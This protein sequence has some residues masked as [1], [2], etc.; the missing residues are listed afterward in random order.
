MEDFRF[1]LISLSAFKSEGNKELYKLFAHAK[2]KLEGAETINK[3]FYILSDDECTSFSFL[4]CEVFLSIQRKYHIPNDCE[5]LNYHKHLQ[6]YVIQH[7][8]SELNKTIPKLQKHTDG[9]EKIV[10]K[11]NISIDEKLVKLLDLEDRIA[12]C[13]FGCLAKCFT[14]FQ[15]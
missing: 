2:D 13:H 15:C 7:K 12:M 4:N 9:S 1:Y 10:I 5:E 8:I 14:S 11:F 3:I 6:E